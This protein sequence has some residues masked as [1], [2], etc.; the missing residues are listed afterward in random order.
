MKA[1][2]VVKQYNDQHGMHHF[3]KDDLTKV[4]SHLAFEARNRKRDGVI[5]D[6]WTFDGKIFI[7][8]HNETITMCSDLSKLPQR[9][10]RS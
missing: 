6:T 8:D 2:K 9:A 3:I 4:R 10:T 1:K 5:K 7:K